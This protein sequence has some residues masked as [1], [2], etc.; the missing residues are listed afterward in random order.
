MTDGFRYN[1]TVNDLPN[2]V[3]RKIY[4]Y[5]LGMKRDRIMPSRADLKPEEIL[6][7]LPYISLVDVEPETKRYKMR[8]IGSET[9]KAMSADM[10]GK[11]LDEVPLIEALLKQNY[12]WLVEEKQPYLNFDK[13][14]WSSKS[15]LEYYALGMPLSENGTDVNMLMFGMFYQFPLE[16]RT[17]FQK[18]GA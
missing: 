3:L 2:D 16:K 7:L 8:L 10:T 5:W 9:V 15:Y 11:Y 18:I 12:D 13:L 17:E 14:R 4:Q 1:F 6:S